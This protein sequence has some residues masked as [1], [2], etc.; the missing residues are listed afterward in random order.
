MNVLDNYLFW[1]SGNLVKM[2]KYNEKKP[3]Q[4]AAMCVT[5]FCFPKAELP[6]AIFA[7]YCIFEVIMAITLDQRKFFENTFQWEKHVYKR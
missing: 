3:K 1:Q 7:E 5:S 2:M 4:V 6:I